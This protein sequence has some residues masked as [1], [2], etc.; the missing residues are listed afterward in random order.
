MEQLLGLAT[1]CVGMSLDDFCRLTP[2][3]FKAVHQAWSEHQEATQRAEW[4][5]T[6]LT[7]TYLLQPWAKRRIAPKDVMR[8]PWDDEGAPDSA[9]S[10]PADPETIRR[11][12]REALRRYGMDEN[13]D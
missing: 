8:L 9:S 7:C 5:R 3:E 11:R 2:S 4:E 12:Y 10:E 13:D 1:G 6:R